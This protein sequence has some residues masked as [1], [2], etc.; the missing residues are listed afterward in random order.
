MEKYVCVYKCDLYY[1][2]IVNAPYGGCDLAISKVR[3]GREPKSFY[4]K[5][6]RNMTEARLAMENRLPDAAWEEENE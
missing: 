6:C 3:Q 2:T 4:S 5:H 1:A